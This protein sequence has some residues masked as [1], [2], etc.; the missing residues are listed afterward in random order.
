VESD[1]A[2]ATEFERDGIVTEMRTASLPVE[3]C[4]RAEEK[5]GEKFGS[6]ENLLEYVL[7]HLLR[8][9]AA[10]AD[11]REHL[12]IEERLRELGYI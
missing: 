9:D 8:D 3:L 7:Q 10:Q 4:V 2:I 11:E 6:L 1:S 12:I 5:F